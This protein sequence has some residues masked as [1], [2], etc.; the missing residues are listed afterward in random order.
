MS[1]E[2]I[3]EIVSHDTVNAVAH[4]KYTHPLD[5]NKVH[6]DHYDLIH[7]I[8]GTWKT[9]ENQNLSF[10]SE[11]Q[12]NVINTLIGWQQQLF[13]NDSFHFSHGEKPDD[14]HDRIFVNK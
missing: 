11:M 13:K 12:A 1:D 6:E 9:L 3:V 5:P 8:P 2:L 10:T 4:I 14:F 7:V